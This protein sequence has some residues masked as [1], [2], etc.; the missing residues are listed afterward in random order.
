M[1]LADWLAGRKSHAARL[2]K[3]IEEL[4]GPA[5]GVIMLP[6]HLSFPGLRECDVTDE[7]ARR[8]VYGIILTL[9]QGND[10]ARYVNPDLLRADW[11]AISETLELR[12]RETCERRFELGDRLTEV[13]EQPA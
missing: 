1:S 13:A 2:P 11:P 4:H 10:V 5:Q 6:R 7:T 3:R 12:L 9:G 8:S